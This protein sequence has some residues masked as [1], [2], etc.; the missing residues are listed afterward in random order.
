[1]PSPTGS[2]SAPTARRL[3]GVSRSRVQVRDAG[4]GREVLILRGAP[5]RWY[6]GGFNPVLAWSPEGT[7]LAATNWDHSVSVWSGDR[8]PASPAQRWE[9]AR[10]RVFTWHLDEAEAAIAAVQAAAAG[11]HLDRLRRG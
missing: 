11:F 4:D 2:R 1:M 6:D 7:R 3:A 10:S 5:S 9:T 8:M